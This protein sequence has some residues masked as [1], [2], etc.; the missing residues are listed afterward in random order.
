MEEQRIEYALVTGAT[1]GLGKSFVYALAKRGYALLLTG[2]SEEKLSALKE[3]V[4]LAYP[5]CYVE[6]YA[7]DLSDEKS[8]L[9]MMGKIVSKGRKISFLANVAGADVQKALTEYTQE[10]IAFQ[11]RVNFESV[12]ALSHFAI[13]QKAERLQILNVSSVSGIYPMPYFAIYSATKGAMTSFSQSLQHSRVK[14]TLL[15]IQSLQFIT[16]TSQTSLYLLRH[17][18]LLQNRLF[19]ITINS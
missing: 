9:A 5:N 11:C 12:V 6:T 15:C 2:R 16:H 7:A 4:R 14:H 10:K 19:S 13:E 1:G 3:E 17:C 8:R 18:T